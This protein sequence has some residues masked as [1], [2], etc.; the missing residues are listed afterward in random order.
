MTDW[1][2]LPALFDRSALHRTAMVFADQ[3][4]GKERGA[5][6]GTWCVALSGGADSL[7]LLLTIWTHW[8][9]RRAALNVLHFNHRLR[10]A[11]SDADQKFCEAICA[12]LGVSI[13]A[14]SWKESHTGASEAEAR[15]ARMAFFAD[16][17]RA[18]GSTV[19]WTGHQKDDIAET[20]L[21]RIARGSSVAGLA[22]PRPVQRLAD[23][24]VFLRPLLT[25]S[26]AEIIFALRSVGAEWREDATNATGAFFRNRVRSEVVPVWRNA[27]ENDALE[28]AALTREF[29]D[30]DDAALERWLEELLPAGVY[31]ADTVDLR[32]LVGRPRALWRRALRRWRPLEKLGRAGFEAVVHMCETGEGRVSVDAG[33]ADIAGG[34]LRYRARLGAENGNEWGP[35]ALSEESTLFFPNGDHLS[36][37]VVEIGVELKALILRGQVDPRREAFLGLRLERVPLQIRAWRDGDRYHP[38]GAPGSAKLQDLFVNRKIS[39]GRRKEL[40]VVCGAAG[41]IIW[42]PGFPPAE[43]TK[44]TVD[45]VIGLRLTYESGT[46]TVRPQSLRVNV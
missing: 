35:I 9:E 2:T 21:M 37:Q 22:A 31:Q 27:A 26:K 18:V 1:K 24:R 25:R 7:A 39:Q 20:L 28:G 41:E 45:S 36:L 11:E 13:R 15:G 40:P 42:V 10:G 46:C 16:E 4:G 34:I 3:N 12:V 5:G 38:L 29:L 17:M 8:P 19:L 23:G 30:E 14:G 33:W 32:A 6:A 44:I 43:E